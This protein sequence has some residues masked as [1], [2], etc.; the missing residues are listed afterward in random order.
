[1]IIKK[2]SSVIITSTLVFAILGFLSFFLRPQTWEGS[3]IIQTGQA[4]TGNIIEPLNDIIAKIS[5]PTFISRT[6]ELLQLPPKESLAIFNLYKESNRASQL[7]G[8]NRFE[9]KLKAHSRET[10]R[11]LLTI[12]ANQILT[13][14]N[15]RLPQ[16]VE[17]IK[18][19]I[20]QLDNNINAI[21]KEIVSINNSPSVM[22][23]TTNSKTLLE[24][25][26]ELRERKRVTEEELSTQTFPTKVIG[27]IYVSKEPISP[28]Q[29]HFTLLV[30]FLGLISSVACIMVYDA[31]KKQE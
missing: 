4:G 13:T 19:R 29:L 28:P 27:D 31:T 5:H 23:K 1:M 18:F 21:T 14:H 12:I 6:T 24:Q 15:E 8:L 9:V 10:V 22:H 30:T 11:N 26:S 20:H 17:Q 16:L 2:Y 25:R 7:N 3:I